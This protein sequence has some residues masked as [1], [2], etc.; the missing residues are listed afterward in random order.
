MS[1]SLL[2]ASYAYCDRVAR[3][4]ASNFYPAFRV[5]PAEQRR[6]MCALYAFL[7][8]TDDLC[9]GTGTDKSIVLQDWYERFRAALAGRYSHRIHAA[10]TDAI[11]RF[12]IPI[13]YLDAVFAGVQMDLEVASYATFTDLYRYCYRVASAVGLS[14]IHIWG[15]DRE[16]A[17]VPAE[18]AGIG[19]Q[20]TNI[21]RDLGEDAAR[22]RV[23][24]PQEDL[25]RFG[26]T[27]ADLKRG[28]RNQAFRQ[29]MQF[30]I[31]RARRYYCAAE[32]LTQFL[33]P[34]GKAVFLAMMR[35]YAGLLS[36]IE[37]RDYDVFTSRIQLGRWKKLRL[38]LQTMPVRYG[39]S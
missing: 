32:P 25:K 13:E 16:E 35:T 36:V 39:W 14:C 4:Q 34:A 1:T 11:K 22:G 30:Q 38:I 21:L 15:F 5:L 10:L 27:V 18:S 2:A 12:A 17:K 29:L 37:D 7:R 23:Y 3:A 20:L 8:I 31:E 19:F 33:R 9:D 28:E 24:L 26:Y 6:G